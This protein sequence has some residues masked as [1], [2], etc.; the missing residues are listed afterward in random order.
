MPALAQVSLITTANPT[1]GLAFDP[2]RIDSK[3]VATWYDAVSDALNARNAVSISVKLPA[4]GGQVARVTAKVVIP[5]IDGVTSAK[6]GDAIATAEFVIPVILDTDARLELLE[7]LG[8]Y[9]ADADVVTC[10]SQLK[11]F[12]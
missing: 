1:P 9:L 4:N 6:I 11:S 10:V 8:A 5:V 2:D 3:G 7:R 12:Y